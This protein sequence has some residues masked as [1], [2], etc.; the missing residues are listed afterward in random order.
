M[1]ETLTASTSSSCRDVLLLSRDADGGASWSTQSDIANSAADLLSKP[2]S[3]HLGQK[4]RCQRG[5]RPCVASSPVS[6]DSCFGWGMS[7]P[8]VLCTASPVPPSHSSATTQGT[9]GLKF[10]HLVK[11]AAQHK[12]RAHHH[13]HCTTTRTIN[14]LQLQWMC[15]CGGA[16][17]GVRG[18]PDAGQLPAAE[19]LRAG[20]G[21]G[22]GRGGGRRRARRHAPAAAEPAR[23]PLPAPPRHCRSSAPG[24]AWKKFGTA[25]P[26]ADWKHQAAAALGGF[27]PVKYQ[28]LC[29]ARLQLLPPTSPWTGWKDTQHACLRRVTDRAPTW[30]RGRLSI[31][32]R[33]ESKFHVRERECNLGSC[34]LERQLS[35]ECFP[36]PL[37]SRDK[38]ACIFSVIR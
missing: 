36:M 29:S 34:G 14:S 15:C 35:F 24:P 6:Q 11:V 38:A 25:S 37:W 20:L 8:G 21:A 9:V 1:T 5:R 18:R 27:R 28:T 2:G 19:G 31:S 22:P 33:Q 3:W 32:C 23:A 10:Q 13:A 12:L 17:V 7:P 4:C 26:M 30:A 16:G